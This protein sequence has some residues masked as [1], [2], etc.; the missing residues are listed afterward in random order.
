[1]KLGHNPFLNTIYVSSSLRRG[2]EIPCSCEH[3]SILDVQFNVEPVTTCRRSSGNGGK[4]SQ[5]QRGT[6]AAW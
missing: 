4:M 3:Y 5:S 2:Y 1:M 6:A